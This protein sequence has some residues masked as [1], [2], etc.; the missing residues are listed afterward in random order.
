VSDEP[1][2]ASEIPL[3]GHA[4]WEAF[5]TYDWAKNPRSRVAHATAPDGV[6]DRSGARPRDRVAPA[7]C[8]RKA[9]FSDTDTPRLHG[10]F[11]RH[12]NH[13]AC[14]DCARIIA[15]RGA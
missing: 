5:N 1:S 4:L 3:R 10:P 2:S 7:L 13:K 14:A 9:W 15:S 12:L 8:G 11:D 6:Y